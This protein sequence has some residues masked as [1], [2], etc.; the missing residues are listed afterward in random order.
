MVQLDL[1]DDDMMMEQSVEFDYIRRNL[2]KVCLL[3]LFAFRNTD[4]LNVPMATEIFDLL[5]YI[6]GV[7]KG[8]QWRDTQ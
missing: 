5:G 2:L 3:R 1:Q 6:P 4:K 8:V 7:A